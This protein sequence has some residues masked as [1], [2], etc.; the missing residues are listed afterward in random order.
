[1][2]I[3]ALANEQ[4]PSRSDSWA[5]KGKRGTCILVAG[6]REGD[7]YKHLMGVYLHTPG[8]NINQHPLYTLQPGL[9]G[10]IDAWLFFGRNQTKHQGRWWITTGT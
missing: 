8:V 1:L 4:L 2:L 5:Q 6:Q 9:S 3:T 10:I 7:P